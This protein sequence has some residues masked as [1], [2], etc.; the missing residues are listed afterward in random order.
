[1]S[2]DTLPVVA[3]ALGDPAGIGPELIA[4]LL[5]DPATCV[6][7]NIVLAGDP[8]LWQAGQDVAGVQVPMIPVADFAQVRGRADAARP[9]FLKIDTVMPEQVERGQAQATG[10]VSALR[11]LDACMDAALAGDIDAIC[12]APLNKYALKLGGMKHEDELH[13]FAQHLGVSGYFCEFNTLEGL[14]T[15]RVSSHVPLRDAPSLIDKP[16]IIAAAQLIYRSLQATGVAAP[17]VA[18]AAL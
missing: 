14:W 3:L 17:R 12:F 7:A 9:A 4:R 6:Q 10:G 16:R 11:V 2:T 13:H 15:S 5:A 1:M 18:V 8:W